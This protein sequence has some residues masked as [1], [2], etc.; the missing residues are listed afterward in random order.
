MPA[1][2][3]PRNTVAALLACIA[4]G[5]AACTELGDKVAFET[6]DVLLARQA[7]RVEMAD[8]AAEK[9]RGLMHRDSLADGRG[10]LFLYEPPSP[11]NFWMKNV[12]F[13]LDLLFF[14]QD[15]C[16]LDHHD[17]VP[18]CPAPPCPVYSTP[19]PTTWVL[20]VPAGTREGL[21]IADGDCALDLS[22]G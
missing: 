10:M 4:T 21:L 8:T 1:T 6:R 9:S 13:P 16:L 11:V 19:H 12:R 7:F 17:R 15:G 20:E 2:R 18:P 3:N 22:G 14:D 5:M